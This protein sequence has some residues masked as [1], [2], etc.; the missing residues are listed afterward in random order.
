MG[1]DLV[2]EAP[3]VL[4]NDTFGGEPAADAGA[5]VDLVLV[6]AAF[7]TLS[8][9]PDG[10][11]SYTAG[12]DFPGHDSFT[13]L[14]SVGAAT[15]QA[16]VSLS[17]CSGG[18]TVFSCWMEAPFLAKLAG[19]GY[20]SFREGFE[21]DAVWGGLRSPSTAPA[22][23]SQGITWRTNHPDPPASNE[24]TTGGGAAVSGLWGVYDPSHGYATGSPA[25]CDVNNPPAQCLFKDG[26]TG[27]REA[28][29]GVLYAVGAF[30]TGTDQANLALIL[31]GGAPIGLGRLSVGTQQFFGVIDTA[32]F[33]TFRF[34][35]VDGKI[36]QSRL[37]FADDFT[38]AAQSVPTPTPTPTAIPP[39][40]TPTPTAIP[41]TATPTPTAIPP[42]ATPT[43]T[44]IPPTA[45][46]TPTAIPPTATPTPTAIAPTPTP[47]P[48]AIPPTATPTPT[49]IPPTATPTPTPTAIP[50]TPTPTP[51]PVLELEIFAIQGSG[52]TSPHAGSVVFSGDNVVT[53]V[54]GDGFFMQT[55]VERAD[56]IGETSDGIF[57][58]TTSLP[59]V[60]VGDRVA[61]TGRVGELFGLT[62]IRVL[63]VAVTATGSPL[64]EPQVLDESMPSGAA[65]SVPE[66]ERFEGML[67]AASGIATGPTDPAGIAPVVARSERSFREPGIEFPGLPDLPLW[68]G[69]PEIFELDPDGLLGM[70]D[71]IMVSGQA[72]SAEGVLAEAS[73][74]YR[75]LPG[76][77]AL[78]EPPAVP[79]AVRAPLP[80]ELT[81]ASQDLGALTAA[82]IDD[83]ATLAAISRLVR[84]RLAAPDILAV[85]GVDTIATLQAVADRIAADDPRLGYTPYVA[86]GFDP[87]G[88]NLGFLVRDTVLV[89][90]LET[91]GADLE[92]V[93]GDEAFPTYERPPL[94]LD[95][96][97]V[98]GGS[99]QPI[100]V[101]AT[102]LRSMDGIEGEDGLVRELR[103]EQALRLSELIQHLQLTRPEVPLVVTGNFNAYQFSDG[104]VDVM[105]Q[106][107]GALDPL[108]ALLPGTDVVDPGLV[109]HV[110]SLAAA[111]RYSY[112]AA[113]SAEARDTVLSSRA[114]ARAVA[115]M[116]YARGNADAPRALL[117]DD[118]T[119][120]S[121]S[122]HDGV[123]LYLLVDADLDGVPDVR[124]LCADTRIPE[125]A[126]L[127]ELGVN[128][129][130]LT[131]DDGAFDTA[132]PAAGDQPPRRGFTIVD[133]GG[134]SCEQI[135]ERFDLG[136]G[137]LKHG[138]SSGALKD[139]IEW[140]E[141]KE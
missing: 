33:T 27:V 110:L 79:R 111:E 113:G 13:Y 127:L 50:P 138:C 45:T 100:V 11:F 128:R 38:I 102:H 26:V 139:W 15:S 25:A 67:V 3:G 24:L 121:V 6:D 51:T 64:P 116:A 85:Q 122:D 141:K 35:E 101:V 86:E 71:E 78:G 83:G 108:G 68:D 42:T 22:A 134:C 76:S 53:A 31:D 137:H 98:G 88:R 77:L 72:F 2:V 73:G 91:F 8:L 114:A 58:L 57:V 103:H 99:S 131:D 105:G 49:A 120:V 97:H 136:K 118:G 69:N 21:D 34:E 130:A 65:A 70:P 16:T 5:V 46:P 107:T 87:A 41:P 1:G 61:V 95:A 74:R 94:V 123:V 9:N 29:A 81:V 140:I 80:F 93:V 112:V 7:G 52:E 20:G 32:G 66:L 19:L 109:N 117:V 59:A 39:T 125:G 133:T 48:T 18:P 14:V 129:W 36:G 44:A 56:G 4:D 75:L 84:E 132:A 40:A 28:G 119:P 55:P 96:E 115:A 37:V 54:R 92:L 62:R 104:Y 60:Q 12:V 63:E 43:P 106:L 126:P 89:L 23:T 47:T 17:A 135:A 30:F 90:G 124:D 10:S 82:A